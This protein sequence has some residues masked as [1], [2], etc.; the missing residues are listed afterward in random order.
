MATEIEATPPLSPRMAAAALQLSVLAN[1]AVSFSC[2]SIDTANESKA[3]P[4]PSP[5]PKADADTERAPMLTEDAVQNIQPV[6]SSVPTSFNTMP[7][8]GND[9]GMQLQLEVVTKGQLSSAI[10]PISSGPITHGSLPANLSA[11]ANAEHYGQR[12]AQRPSPVVLLQRPPFREKKQRL[13]WTSNMKRAAI[14]AIEKLG[15]P[16]TATPKKILQVAGLHHVTVLQV[17]A[18]RDLQCQ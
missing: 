5:A 9:A 3:L 8:A 11:V 18:V 10:P 14:V 4:S 15:G 17:S 2:V 12:E 6:A 13:R 1:T 7:S 16:V